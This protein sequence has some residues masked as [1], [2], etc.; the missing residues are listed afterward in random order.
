MGCPSFKNQQGYIALGTAIAMML[1]SLIAV[2]TSTLVS[3]SSVQKANHTSKERSHFFAQ[4]GIE[5]A[6]RKIDTGQDPEITNFPIGNGTFS[7]SV[8][9]PTVTVVGK[10]DIAETVY[11]FGQGSGFAG[12][13]LT[14]SCGNLHPSGD[15]LTTFKFLKPPECPKTPTI[16]EIK[17]AWVPDLGEA[18]KEIQINGTEVWNFPPGTP[19]D[20]W[21]DIVDYTIPDNPNTPVNHWEFVSPVPGGKDYTFFIKFADGSV[22]EKT[23]EDV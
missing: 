9:P 3:S 10:S 17:V 5:Y 4:A 6:K 16:L 1:M 21:M 22:L 11:R 12:D 23:C 15:Q 13:C 7:V 14:L 2:G 20:V 18:M 8:D 19:S